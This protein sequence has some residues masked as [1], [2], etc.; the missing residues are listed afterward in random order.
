MTETG[1]E[2]APCSVLIFSCPNQA[3]IKF[4]ENISKYPVKTTEFIFPVNMHSF[5]IF[6]F[7]QNVHNLKLISL[8]V[9]NVW[10]EFF[11]Q[12][13]PAFPKDSLKAFS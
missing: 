9:S 10:V 8:V 11:V 6:F 4:W 3:K 12:S 2:I 7:G 5:W 13:F 1:R